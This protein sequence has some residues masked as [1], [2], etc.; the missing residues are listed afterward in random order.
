M[1]GVARS[2][3]ASTTFHVPM[4]LV[5]QAPRGSRADSSSQ[6]DARTKTPSVPLITLRTAC[7]SVMFAV[8]NWNRR[9]FETRS[10]LRRDP[11]RRSSNTTTEPACASS[12][13]SPI[14]DPMKPAPPTR[15]K[16]LP[17][18][19]IESRKPHTEICEAHITCGASRHDS[20]PVYQHRHAHDLTE[21][22]ERQRS[23]FV[24]GDDERDRIC[25]S[26]NVAVIATH[27]LDKGVVD[28]DLS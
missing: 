7:A 11:R 26:R 4:T 10:R 18:M 5:S 15:T 25:G 13:C 9:S 12:N 3:Q 22:R 21:L 23:V 20:A 6:S 19:S 14:C 1:R 2:R 24:V 28:A 27:A 16:R 8:T 17:R